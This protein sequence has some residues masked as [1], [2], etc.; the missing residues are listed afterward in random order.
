MLV[1][2]DASAVGFFEFYHS[3]QVAHSVVLIMAIYLQDSIQNVCKR[4]TNEKLP[5]YAMATN[6]ENEH[7][8][9]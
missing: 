8:P 1:D 5:V 2:S 9:T 3:L 7:I 4:R 6:G